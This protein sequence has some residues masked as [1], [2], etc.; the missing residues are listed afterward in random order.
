[1]DDDSQVFNWTKEHFLQVISSG[2]KPIVSNQHLLDAFASLNREDFIPPEYAHDVYGDINDRLKGLQ[3]VESPI[4]QAQLLND[5]DL[6]PN[7]KVL[8]LGT[9]S[10]YSLALISKSVGGQGFVYSVERDQ[11]MLALA[12]EN[13]AKYDLA[14]N[15]ELVFKDAGEGLISK[16]P[17]DRIYGSFAFKEVPEQILLQLKVGGKMILP[18][19]DMDI[20]LITRIDE[21]DFED[22][23]I[24]V[25]EL[26]EIFHGVE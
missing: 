18:L 5:L 14:A 21:E 12:R 8:E 6:S 25:K 11:Q 2:R 19:N 24:A 23:L 9:G 13:L 22:Q 7:Q 16:S 1:M 10:G 3:I 17:F 26:P 20:K 15:F 4:L